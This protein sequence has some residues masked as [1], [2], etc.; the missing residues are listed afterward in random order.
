MKFIS[1]NISLRIIISLILFVSV[2]LVFITCSSRTG[3][4]PAATSASSS[5]SLHWYRQSIVDLGYRITM[6]STHDGVAISRGRGKEFRGHA[7]RFVNGE[8]KSFYD[9]PYSDYPLLSIKDS[10]S[11]FW[12]INHLTHDGAY[13]PVHSEFTK[14]KRKEILIP[15]IMWDEI[16]YVMFKGI[17]QFSDGTAWMVGQQG[18]IVY[19][20]GKQWKEVESPLIHHDRVNVYDGDLNDVY[21]LS[22]HSGWAVG[23]DGI[24]LRYQ[25]ETWERVPSPT[26]N[27]LFRVAFADENN[28]WAVGERGTILKWSGTEWNSEL[29]DTRESLNSLKVLD[30]QHVWVVGNSSTLLCFNGNEWRRDETITMYDD[31]FADLDVVVDEQG[32]LQ[33]WII[34]DQGIYTTSNSTGFSFT[35]ITGQA[36]LRRVGRGGMFFKRNSEKVPDLLVLNDGGINLLYEN[37]GNNIFSDVTERAGILDVPRDA[38]ITALGDVNNDGETDLL[39]IGDH[40][41]FRLYFGTLSGG[42][43]D[44]TEFSQ[45]T[46][47]EINPSGMNA[48]RFVDFDNDGNL[49]L[50]I[51]NYDLHD[52]LF[53][54]DGTGRFTSVTEISGVTKLLNHSSYGVAFG[55]F[56][57]DGF[58][59]IFV[60]Y[61]VSYKGK[62]FDL[63]LNKGDFTFTSVDDPS[64][65]SATDISPTVAVAQDF[66]NDGNCDIFVH[67]QKSPPYLLLNDGTG[68]FT[69]GAQQAGLTTINFHA[70]PS[71]GVVAVADVNND[72]WM[73]IFD[74]SKLYLNSPGLHFTEVSERVGV[75]FTGNP[76]FADID[77]DG[78]MDL[79]IGSSRYAL[80]KGDRAA[81]FRNNLNPAAYEK[82]KM[83]PDKSNRSGIGTKVILGNQLRTLGL[84]SSP[85]LPGITNEEIVFSADSL[86]QRIK[87]IF[88]SGTEVALDETGTGEV[89]ESTF[90]VRWFIIISKSVQRTLLLLDWRIEIPKLALLALFY[91]GF[92][93]F[94]N[95]IGAKKFVQS[96][97]FVVVLSLFYIVVIHLLSGM[98]LLLSIGVNF[99]SVGITG[100]SS[101]LI[102]RVVIQKSEARYISHYKILELLG[103]GGMGKVY[104]AVDSE[105]KNIVALKVL[106]PELLKDPEN[107]RRLSA[108]GHVLASFNHP[109]IVKVFE[110]GESN[111]RGFIAMEYLSGG[112]LREKL[113]KEHP[114][115]I[116][117]IKRYVLQVCDGLAEVHAKGIVHRDLKTGNLMLDDKGNIRI[118][119]FGLSK[120]PLVTTM[121]SLG[122][123]LGTLGY[124]AP[125]QVTGV[126]ADHRTDIFSLGVIIYELLTKELPFKGENEIALIH[127]IFNTIPTPPSV[128]RNDLRKQ[129]DDIVLKCLAKDANE[130]YATVEEIKK[131]VISHNS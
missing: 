131:Q 121:T 130:R 111:E 86:H 64:F 12:T 51:S 61:Y 58:I 9:F 92:V 13:R 48:A 99:L 19:Y 47:N 96:T 89:H 49:D 108:E 29:T 44:V 7:Y 27:K 82:L 85:M 35:D 21:M 83:Y 10:L 36:S 11:Q 122:T 38:V 45:L 66:N 53:K 30:T 50:Y 95:T 1:P 59:D 74:G 105:T 112:T 40:T 126:N 84:N 104:K 22:P 78:D 73:D 113:E 129:W 32:E 67:N 37:N 70:E 125:E 6:F 68:H 88:P 56:N 117:Q 41:N 79:F 103:T 124:V 123:V 80:G 16:D 2:T 127:S 115:S 60:P 3:Q 14:G 23:R 71:N 93:R 34:G 101:I 15:K 120:S 116:E 76:S 63:F 100:V 77:N 5:K 57:N 33:Y 26:Q 24:I 31:N 87:I 18:H 72:G 109:H 28:G 69:N 39:S 25:N 110:I 65:H 46:F 8:W 55:D 107:R 17:H 75:Q 4:Q 81:L 90:P 20:D 42:F 43:R 52:Q 128:V 91:F 102:A 62:F 54:N 98:S 97:H 118:M 114:L 119:D 106:N 94:G